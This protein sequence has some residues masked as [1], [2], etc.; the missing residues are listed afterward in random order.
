MLDYTWLSSCFTF[1]LPIVATVVNSVYFFVA[2]TELQR[3]HGRPATFVPV[4]PLAYWQNAASGHIQPETSRTSVL[5]V[6]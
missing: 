6:Q 1:V 2:N 3:Q 5:A 4:I